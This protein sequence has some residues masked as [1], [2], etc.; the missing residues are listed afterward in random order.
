MTCGFRLQTDLSVGVEGGRVRGRHVLDAGERVY[1]ALSWAEGFAAPADVDD[2]EQ[3]IAATV[4]F[5]RRWLDGARVPDHRYRE[6]IQRSALAIKGLTYMPTG[7]TVAALTTGLPE[8]PGGERNW[9]YRY[10]WMRDSTFTLQALHWLNLDWEA[11]EF[12]Q[13]VADLERER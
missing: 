12:M 8:T 6:P 1:C 10:S 5:W 2:A 11:D 9:D 4:G 3:R 7:A 13:F